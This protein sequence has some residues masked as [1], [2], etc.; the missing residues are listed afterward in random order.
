MNSDKM[1]KNK[2]K[3]PKE[4]EV[5]VMNLQSLAIFRSHFMFSYGLLR[6]MLLDGS[7]VPNNCNAMYKVEAHHHAVS[8]QKKIKRNNMYQV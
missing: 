8:F 2:N 7:K 4:S 5:F 1:R 6:W 3:M